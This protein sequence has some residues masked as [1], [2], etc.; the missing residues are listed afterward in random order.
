MIF[1]FDPKNNVKI[2]GG[3]Y[4][5]GCYSEKYPYFLNMEPNLSWVDPLFFV[6][7]REKV[8][9]DQIRPMGW[10]PNIS[11]KDFVTFDSGD[12]KMRITF[13]FGGIYHQHSWWMAPFNNF[14]SMY[15]SWVVLKLRNFSFTKNQVLSLPIPIIFFV[16]GNMEQYLNLLN[17]VRIVCAR[18][19]MNKG[20]Q[21]DDSDDMSTSKLVNY[22]CRVNLKANQKLLET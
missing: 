16:G 20:L 13:I 19:R 21:H 8:F 2:H 15:I 14:T 17:D 5:H 1:L 3:T 10:E 18:T 7:F 4:P 11:L 6:Y 9:K 22:L 12:I